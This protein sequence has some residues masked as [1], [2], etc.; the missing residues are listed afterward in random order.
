MSLKENKLC[1]WLGQTD[2]HI[3]TAFM[4]AAFSKL[5]GDPYAVPNGKIFLS[6]LC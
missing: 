4:L 6:Y 2:P 1:G 3:D 5:L